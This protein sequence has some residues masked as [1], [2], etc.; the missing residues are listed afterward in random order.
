VQ[1]L[2]D[3]SKIEQQNFTLSVE[4]FDAAKM[5]GEIET[6]LQHKASEKD[7]RFELNIPKDPLYVQGD[8]YRLKQVFLNL[9]NNAL[10]YTPEHG[11]VTISAKLAEEDIQIE[12]ADTGIGI[13]KEE[14]PRIFERFYRVDKDRSRNSGGT[15]L[16]LAIVKHLIEAH[17]G[18]IEVK[19]E[20]G[21]GTIFIV[22]L[23]RALN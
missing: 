17:E 12:V 10:T 18:K 23:K 7:I 20:Q 5:L 19:S 22:A 2:L 21:Q 14:I 13:E 16:G 1:D 6:L 3:L 8:V 15:G 11:T 9:A 4:T